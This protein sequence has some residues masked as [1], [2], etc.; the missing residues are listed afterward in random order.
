MYIMQ[1]WQIF[2]KEEKPL[3]KSVIHYIK[4]Y[5]IRKGDPANELNEPAECYLGV[6]YCR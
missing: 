5:F 1:Q 6:W 2:L 3:S 4:Y